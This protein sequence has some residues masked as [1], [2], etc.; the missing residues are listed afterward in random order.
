MS[1]Y[2]WR[3]CVFFAT[4][5]FDLLGRIFAMHQRLHDIGSLWWDEHNLSVVA[6]Y[7]TH[8]DNNLD[9]YNPSWCHFGHLMFIYL[10]MGFTHARKIV[11][12]LSAP[13][14]WED[15]CQGSI[16]YH[17]IFILYRRWGSEIIYI[18]TIGTKDKSQQ[19]I[20]SIKDWGEIFRT[21]MGCCWS[22]YLTTCIY[23]VN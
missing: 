18:F 16:T 12:K 1:L 17:S 21:F 4:W 11:M 5:S 13:E 6:I 8:W 15:N 2:E 22:G 10:I 23:Y 3:W 14:K 20:S 9:K 7:L 19:T